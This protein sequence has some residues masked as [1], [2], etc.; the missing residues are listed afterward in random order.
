MSLE[1]IKAELKTHGIDGRKTRSMT[2]EE[3][4]TLLLELKAEENATFE[5]AEVVAEVDAQVA[6]MDSIE[7]EEEPEPDEYVEDLSIENGE[8]PEI[9]SRNWNNF[10]LSQLTDDE[11]FE[12][13]PT[14]Q[15]LRRFTAFMF[16]INDIE[17]KVIQ[18]PT[19]DNDNRATVTVR[20]CTSIG[21][22][23]SSADIYSGNSGKFGA[24]PVAC[25]DTRAEGRALRRLLCLQGLTAE[26]A[27]EDAI[28]LTK[29]E[30]DGRI[31]DTQIEG[32]NN[33][34]KNL[35]I[36]VVNLIKETLPDCSNISNAEYAQGQELLKAIKSFKTTGV[37][38]DLKGFQEGWKNTLS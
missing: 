33:L 8:K 13:K 18:C 3:M 25:A 23:S 19:P 15:G 22:A 31:N 30:A 6:I 37:P 27:D 34:C 26:E 20:I 16:G 29:S 32:I 28:I 12:G 24:H 7:D 17:S 14:T 5:E 9:G 1:N 21:N 36:D 4:E 38:D 2:Q 11:K 35:D 10:V